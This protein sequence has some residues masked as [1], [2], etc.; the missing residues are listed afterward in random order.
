MLSKIKT[1]QMT[2]QMTEKR[3]RRLGEMCVLEWI[4]YIKQKTQIIIFHGR[5]L[6]KHHSSFIMNAQMRGS[7]HHQEV[8]W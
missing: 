7:K 1:S 6:R 8:Q 4:Y 3:I 5:A 2:W